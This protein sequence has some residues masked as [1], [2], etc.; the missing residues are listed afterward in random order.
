MPSKPRLSHSHQP[1]A[2]LTTDMS[3]LSLDQQKCLADS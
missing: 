1:T 3:E 2:Q